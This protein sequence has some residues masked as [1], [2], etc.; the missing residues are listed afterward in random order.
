MSDYTVGRYLVSLGRPRISGAMIDD[1]TYHYDT[2]LLGRL[3]PFVSVCIQC[4]LGSIGARSEG[5]RPWRGPRKRVR[6]ARL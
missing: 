6:K 2:T 4:R 5:K 3:Y 1:V